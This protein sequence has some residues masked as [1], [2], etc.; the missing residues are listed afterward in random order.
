M[1]ADGNPGRPERHLDRRGLPTL[2]ARRAKTGSEGFTLLEI[3]VAMVLTVFGVLGFAGL[4]RVIGNV[5]AEDTWQ[6]KA[7]FCAE[8]RM[9]ELKF[10]CLTGKGVTTEGEETVTEGSYQGMRREWTT[11]ESP[12][13]EGLLEISVGCGYLWDGS[14]KTV[15]LSTLVYP[16]E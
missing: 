14:M 3:L 11:G 8:E 9:E 1:T 13:F 4:L 7:L 12:V 10:D 2:P 16:E 15:E 6:T 5:E